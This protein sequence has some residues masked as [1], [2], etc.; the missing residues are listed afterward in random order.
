M[1]NDARPEL[2]LFAIFYDGETRP[3]AGF[4]LEQNAQEY[5]IK[6]SG[7]ASYEI[8]QV[9]VIVEPRADTKP[10]TRGSVVEAPEQDLPLTPDK[11]IELL[12]QVL[13]MLEAV[14]DHRGRMSSD[15]P[16]PKARVYLRGIIGRG[17]VHQPDVHVDYRQHAEEIVNGIVKS[18]AD[19]HDASA[20]IEPIARRLEILA[21]SPVQAEH[22]E[23]HDALAFI[24]ACDNQPAETIREYAQDTLNLCMARVR[25]FKDQQ[26]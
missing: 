4:V 15:S 11:A 2:G 9:R 20:L 21:A 13:E 3:V 6:Y 18:L 26:P 24:V 8:K 10:E 25:E 22:G 17:I 12:R 7:G 1:S 16:L 14:T 23:C 5:A 19:S